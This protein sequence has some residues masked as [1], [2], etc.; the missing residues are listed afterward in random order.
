[1]KHFLFYDQFILKRSR[2]VKTI[3]NLTKGNNAELYLLTNPL[4]YQLRSSFVRKHLFKSFKAIEN[5]E[6]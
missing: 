3:Q 6:I 4:A 5:Q 2:L 1:M